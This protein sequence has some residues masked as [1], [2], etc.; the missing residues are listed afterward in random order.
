MDDYKLLLPC[1]ETPEGL[2]TRIVLQ[3]YQPDVGKTRIGGCDISL[4]WACVGRTS[5]WVQAILE[6]VVHRLRKER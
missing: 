6:D 4:G 2:H 1:L 3:I 5:G